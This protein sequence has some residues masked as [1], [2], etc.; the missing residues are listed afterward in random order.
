MNVRHE[1][2]DEQAARLHAFLKSDVRYDQSLLPRPFF[3]EFTGSPSSGKT[4]SIKSLDTFLRRHDFRVF[5]PQE[6]AEVIRH[7][8]RSTPLYNIRTG[9]YALEMLIDLSQGHQ[10]DMVIFDRCV[11]DAYSWMMYWQEKG[12]LT[13]AD[14]SLIQNFFLLPYWM[15]Q[16]DLAYVFTCDPLVATTREDRLSLTNRPSEMTNPQTIGVLVDRY[17]RAFSQLKDGFPQL[18]LVDTTSLSEVEMLETVTGEVLTV[19]EKKAALCS[20]V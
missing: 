2:Y 4:T 17:N 11:F 19:L 1:R 5:C 13:D 10:Y 18:R 8:S 9:L 3:I 16:I 15:N 7:V 6:G 20:A 14:R 12:K